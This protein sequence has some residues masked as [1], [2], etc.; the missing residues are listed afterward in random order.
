MWSASAFSFLKRS[1]ALPIYTFI[2]QMLFT[3][4]VFNDSTRG[5]QVSRMRQSIQLPRQPGLAPT[6]AQAQEPAADS[7]AQDHQQQHHQVQL[8]PWFYILYVQ[9]VT[10]F[11]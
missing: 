4:Q 7:V 1:A 5:V 10:H 3:V 2:Y 8:H 9:E 6:L 11:I